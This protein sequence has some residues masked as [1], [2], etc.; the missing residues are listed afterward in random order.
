MKKI[1]KNI[2]IYLKYTPY[3]SNFLF[4]YTIRKKLFKY[5]YVNGLYTP[6]NTK[7]AF[8]LKNKNNSL[9]K[10]KKISYYKNNIIKLMSFFNKKG[11]LLDKLVYILEVYSIL[12]SIFLNFKPYDI[13]IHDS[14]IYILEFLYNL[15]N[16]RSLLNIRHL[17]NWITVWNNPLFDIG[18]SKVPKKFKKKL[19]KKYTY[20]IVYIKRN[21]QNRRALRWLFLN[22]FNYENIQKLKRQLLLNIFDL[23]LN[24]KKSLLYKQK[25]LIYKKM[26]KKS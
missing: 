22:N 26:F 21:N 8:I 5:D 2:T 11:C 3:N 20:K 23:T 14:Y 6:Q 24:Y 19:K 1:K 9:K 16:I 25:I 10:V 18:V 7:K 15:L 4:F 13:L 17:L 12:Y